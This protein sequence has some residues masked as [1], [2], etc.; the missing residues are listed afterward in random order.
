MI[1]IYEDAVFETDAS[2]MTTQQSKFLE[3]YFSPAN[4]FERL[5]TLDP[6]APECR[7]YDLWSDYL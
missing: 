6:S 4:F 7:E 1:N 5:C 3:E 2:P